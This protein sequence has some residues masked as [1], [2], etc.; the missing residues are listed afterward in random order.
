MEATPVPPYLMDSV[1]VDLFAMPAVTHDGHTYD[2]MAVCVDRLS[3]WMV[4]TPMEGSKGV[5]ADKVAKAMYH[6]WDMFGVPAVVASD[7]GSQFTSAWWQTLCAALGVRWAYGQAYHHQANGRA[8]VAGQRIMN[9]LSKLVTDI[10]VPEA[11]WVTLLPKALRHLHDAPGESGYSPYEIVFGRHRP[12]QGLPRDPPREAEDA[13]DFLDRMQNITLKVAEKLNKTHEKRWKQ[14][15]AK[16]RDPPPLAVGAKVWYRPEPQPGTDKLAP[17]WKRGVV[18]ARVSHHGYV[19]EL[20]PDKRQEAYRDQLKPHT[21]DVYNTSPLPLFYFSGKASPV[22]VGPDDYDVDK[23]LNHQVNKKTGELEF[24]VRW[25]DWDPSDLKW[26]PW[27]Q[28][29]HINDEVV[30]YCAENNIPLEMVE[31]SRKRIIDKGKKQ[32]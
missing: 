13:T 16:R 19:V 12:L 29:F 31:L 3:G 23:I 15:N 21:E 6:Q 7:R 24:L 20:G 10:T 9:V 22:A 1:A 28:F 4:A 5:T 32:D 18:L 17:K 14:I 25:K 27:S 8:E 2:W 30:S 11:S 26:E